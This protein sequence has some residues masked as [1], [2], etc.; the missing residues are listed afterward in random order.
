MLKTQLLL[1]ILQLKIFVSAYIV[2]HECGRKALHTLRAWPDYFGRPA[3]SDLRVQG[4][5]GDKWVGHAL[6]FFSDEKL[7]PNGRRRETSAYRQSSGATT[8]L[9]DGTHLAIGTP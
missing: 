6:L 9:L 5:S 1:K 8:C 4:D 2:P 3:Y 7:S